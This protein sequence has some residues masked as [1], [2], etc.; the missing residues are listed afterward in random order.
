MNIISMIQ[1]EIFY[2][3]IYIILSTQYQRIGIH[4]IQ[5]NDS[6]FGDS[7]D[8][9]IRLFTSNISKIYPI[10]N[11]IDEQSHSSNDSGQWSSGSS[12][13]QTSVT[14]VNNISVRSAKKSEVDYRLQRQGNINHLIYDSEPR[15][16]NIISY[17]NRYAI[18]Q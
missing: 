2:I 15:L 14:A 17:N 5:T 12:N 4:S 13:N 3:Y 9:S 18:H 8:P 10:N 1:M 16:S 11:D 6:G 7:S